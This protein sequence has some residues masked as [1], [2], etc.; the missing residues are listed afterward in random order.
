MT[1]PL[2]LPPCTGCGRPLRRPGQIAAEHPGTILAVSGRAGT[3]W[4]CWRRRHPQP[5]ATQIPSRDWMAQ[6]LCAQI[7]PDLWYPDPGDAH[8]AQTAA[9]VCHTCPVRADCLDYAMATEAQQDRHGVWGGLTPT[10]RNR[11]W[12]EQRKEAA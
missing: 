1:L 8:A 2:L 11:L 4:A 6:A 9:A 12:H 5:P 7:D 10:A 3:C